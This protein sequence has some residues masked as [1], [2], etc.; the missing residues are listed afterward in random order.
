VRYLAVADQHLPALSCTKLAFVNENDRQQVERLLA[1][2]DRSAGVV[3]LPNSLDED[4]KGVYDDALIFLSKVLQAEGVTVSWAQESDKRTYEARRS[5]AEVIWGAA[6]SF[7]VNVASALAAV[8]LQQWLGQS[9]RRDNRVRFYVAQAESPDGT[10]WKWQTLEGT[11][12]EVAELMNGLTPPPSELPTP[13]PSEPTTPPS[14]EPP[15]PPL[16]P[17][18]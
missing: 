9:P 11:G 3:F 10:S 13:P 18:E 16:V 14:S 15:G 12:A 7:P 2:S 6:L 5:A 17:P 1:Q 8:K 4:G